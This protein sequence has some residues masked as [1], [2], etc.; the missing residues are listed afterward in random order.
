MNG[1]QDT[2]GKHPVSLNGSRGPAE[3]LVKVQ[4]P[5]REDLQPTYAQVIQPDTQD[6]SQHGWYG[7][8]Y[9]HSQTQHQVAT[10]GY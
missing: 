7:C 8:K 9:I 2:N 1:M 3:P 10:V 4:P 5:R 6:D